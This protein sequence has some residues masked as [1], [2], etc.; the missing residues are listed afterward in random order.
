MSSA[1]ATPGRGSSSSNPGDPLH[2]PGHAERNL[3]TTIVWPMAMLRTL[4]W[5]AFAICSASRLANAA[6]TQAPDPLQ[7]IIAGLPD[8]PARESLLPLV[9]GD[10]SILIDLYTRRRG[11]LLWSTADGATAAAHA[12]V[13]ALQAVAA[14]GLRAEDYGA[15]RL[16]TQ[17]EALSVDHQATDVQRALFDASLSNSVLK[18]LHDLHFGRVDPH[19]AGFDMPRRQDGF[20]GAAYLERLAKQSDAAAVLAEVEPNFLHYRLLRKA[21]TRY[22]AIA[23]STELATLPT[24]SV[25]SVSLGQRYLGAAALRRLLVVL[26]NLPPEQGSRSDPI[27]DGDLAAA[28]KQF[29]YLH[30]LREDGI[31]DKSTYAALTVPLAERVRQIELTL[32]RWRW[33]PPLQAPTLIVNIPEF[34]LFLFRSELDSEADMLRMNVIV[35]R[36]YPKLHT[37]VFTSDMKAVVFRPFW[38]VPAA[39]AQHELLPQLRKNPHYLETQNLELVA[40]NGQPSQP[41]TVNSDSLRA[42]AA[43]QLRLR[44]RPGPDN[45]LGLIKFVLP[46]SYSVYLHSTPAQR[47]FDEPRRAFSHGCIR[48]SDPVALAAAVMQGTAGDWTAD[49]I[50]RAMDGDVTFSV[51]LAHPVHVLI[52]YGTAIASE[53]GAMHFFDD[54]YGED[55]RLEALLGLKP[56]QTQ[57]ATRT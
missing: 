13:G 25:R 44:Q 10:R 49:R 46:N 43:G 48:V 45:A 53:D 39:I 31:L 38:E 23:D 51:I 22:R 20:D 40:S 30:G 21:L 1:V 36:T 15:D 14:Y 17:L 6:E 55:R 47:L 56:V 3:S 50:R 16:A 41:L 35:G 34:R 24:L 57:L 27:L 52:L 11:V 42:L 9:R 33:V 26:G 28:L 32:E 54:I 12:L 18:L 7:A 29:Q 5:C 8:R 19:A 2:K 37:P 4:C